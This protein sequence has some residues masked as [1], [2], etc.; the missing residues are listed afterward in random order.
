MELNLKAYASLKVILL[1]CLGGC[2]TMPAQDHVETLAQLMTGH[3]STAQQAAANSK[4]GVYE[5]SAA[6][7]WTSRR[8]GTW[9]YLEQAE[10]AKKTA[11][12]RQR[13]Y[14]MRPLADGKVQLDMYALKD[15]KRALGAYANGGANIS[16]ADLEPLAGC[17]LVFA[18]ERDGKWLGATNGKDCRNNYK[19]SAYMTSQ[20][21]ITATR[22]VNW[23]RGFRA[24]DS[25]AWG[26][27]DGGY[28]FD[29]Q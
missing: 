11:P 28:V 12:Y 8:D 13:I 21:E 15:P 25:L 3:Y 17:G 5:L 22:W 24:D 10:A 16:D 9:L 4:Y 14:Q 29:R 18:A 23:D 1:L 19:S 2:A 6:R 27:A 26:P 7:I 20:A